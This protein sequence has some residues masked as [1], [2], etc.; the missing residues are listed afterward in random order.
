MVL[1][2]PHGIP[3]PEHQRTVVGMETVA[4]TI[5]SKSR[6]RVRGQNTQA[7]PTAGDAQ[8]P[9]RASNEAT[10]GHRGVGT[11]PGTLLAHIGDAVREELATALR[12]LVRPHQEAQR[13][14]N[15]TS[16]N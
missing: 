7:G 15:S 5:T 6:P 1:P 12:V 9:Q 14:P 8:L 16:D 4:F 10:S 3:V 11:L 2:D 13:G